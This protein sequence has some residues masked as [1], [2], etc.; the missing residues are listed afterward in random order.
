MY[1]AGDSS[2]FKSKLVNHIFKI[3][4]KMIFITLVEYIC[5]TTFLLGCFTTWHYSCN[6][7]PRPQ[8]HKM[9]D[10]VSNRV[11]E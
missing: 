5:K 1:L 4:F 8:R 10:N 7:I 6:S 11:F 9:R 2:P 3:N